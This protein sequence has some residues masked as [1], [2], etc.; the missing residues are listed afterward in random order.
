[1][2]LKGMMPDK[3]FMG[4]AV[5]ALG[6]GAAV[7]LFNKK[8]TDYAAKNAKTWNP[9][10]IEAAPIIGALVFA[11]KQPIIAAAI[12]GAVGRGLGHEFGLY[13][14]SQSDING[15]F[16]GESKPDRVME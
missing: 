8:V 10:A 6:T 9:K 16:G 1:M 4:N 13:G 15:I 7:G 12:L 14:L 11:K 3:K 5:K 2:K